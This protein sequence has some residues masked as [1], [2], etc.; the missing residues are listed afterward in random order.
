M[1]ELACAKLQIKGSEEMVKVAA[2]VRAAEGAEPAETKT[3]AGIAEIT[4]GWQRSK[5]YKPLR[6]SAVLC[7]LCVSSFSA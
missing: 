5:I 3:H 7:D 6:F 4:R 1:P 2:A